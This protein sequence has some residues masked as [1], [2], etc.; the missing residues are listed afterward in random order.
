MDGLFGAATELFP[1]TPKRR[2]NNNSSSGSERNA[3]KKV[4]AATPK[5]YVL[6]TSNSDVPT[7]YYGSLKFIDNKNEFD[8]TFG[9][10]HVL[11]PSNPTSL[12]NAT[13]VELLLDFSD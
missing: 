12:D 9:K 13:T 11:L 6:F 1:N 4:V 3:G 2:D 7:E 10:N 8:A 5:I